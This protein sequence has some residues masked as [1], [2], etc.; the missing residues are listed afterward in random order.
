MSIMV[1][2]KEEALKH[3]LSGML[4][5]AEVD[6]LAA[7]AEFSKSPQAQLAVEAIRKGDFDRFYFALQYPAEQVVDGLL[8]SEIPG[9]AHDVRFLFRHSQFVERHL[10]K[11][12]EKYEGGPCAADKTRTILRAILRFLKTGDEIAFDYGQEYTFHLPKRVFTSHAQ[13]I[14]YFH[15]LKHLYYGNPE[16][17]MKAL[18]AVHQA[19]ALAKST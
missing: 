2:M 3:V 11:L 14:E 12:I 8:A 5:A 16:P 6:T 10:R 17:Y 18:L 9:D 13:T 7:Y 15:G 1:N 4:A 19:A